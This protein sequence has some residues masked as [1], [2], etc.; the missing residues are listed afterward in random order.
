MAWSLTWPMHIMISHD[1]NNTI[2]SLPCL[3]AAHFMWIAKIG[4]FL[5]KTWRNFC[6][7]SWCFSIHYKLQRGLDLKSWHL[8]WCHN[9]WVLRDPS[10]WE[11][12]LT[13]VYP[14]ILCWWICSFRRWTC[15]GT[16]YFLHHL[17]FLVIRS[18]M[19]SLHVKGFKLRTS[20]F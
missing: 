15:T 19:N 16:V 2:I 1:N 6:I 8:W 18:L 7:L 13:S 20:S 9:I 17:Y 10:L 11:F 4:C 14:S 12:E 5:R 3:D